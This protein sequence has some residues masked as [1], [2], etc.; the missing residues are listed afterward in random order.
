MTESKTEQ[1]NT[2]QMLEH[3][4]EPLRR[5]VDQVTDYAIFLLDPEGHIASWNAGAARIKGYTFEEIINQ[6]F[7]VFYRPEDR[8]RCA[9]ELEMAARDGRVED[10]GW[11]VRKDGTLFWADVVITCLRDSAGQIVGYGKVT[12]DLSERQRAEESLRQAEERFRLLV[13]SVKDYAIFMLDPGGHVTTWNAGAERIKGYRAGEI[14]GKHFSTFYPKED[15]AAGKCEMELEVAAREGRFEDE[16]WRLRKD[17]S[18]FWANVVIT[19]VHDASGALIGFAKVTRDLTERRAAEEERLRLGR[20]AQER[21]QALGELSEAL[22]FALS[23]DDVAR[24]VIQ[25]GIQLARGDTC[26]L[27]LLDEKTKTLELLAERGCNPEIVD[28]IRQIT[29]DAADPVYPVGTGERAEL[30]VETEAEYRALYPAF[31]ADQV[32][33]SG[34]QAFGCVPLVAEGKTIGMLGVGYREARDFSKDER[35]FVATVAQQ[36]AQA[37]ARAR[38]VEG[39]REAAALVDHLR[40]SLLTTL[41]SIGDALIATDSD[42]SISLMNDVAETLTG[43]SESDARGKS[44]PEV[45]HIINEHTRNIAENPVARVLATGGIVGLA[46]HTVLLA[47]DGREVPID[48]SGAPIRTRDGKIEGVVLVFRD[49]ST[50]KREEARRA[51]LADA[52]A[53]LGRSLDYEQTVAHVAQLCV[54][55]LADWCTVDLL[56][57]GERLPARLAV[58]HVDPGKIKLAQ[59]LAERYPPDPNHASAVMSVLQTGRSLLYP[60]IPDQLLVAGARDAEQLRIARELELRSAMIVPLIARG[61]VLGAMTFVYAES[62]RH[63]SADDLD[64][65]EQLA[66]RCAAAIDNARLFASE[67]RSRRAAEIANRAKDEFLAVVSHELRTPL[68]AIMGW[69]KLLV[70][71]QVD[72]ARQR[73]ALETVERNAVA[74]AQLVEDLLDMSRVVSGKL[75]LEVQQ[76]NLAQVTSAAIESVRPAAAARGVELTSSL[77]GTAGPVL[78]D[79]T[80]LQ[81]VIWNLLSNAVKFTSRDGGVRIVLRRVDFSVEISVADTGKGIAPSFLPHVFEA[82][83]QQDASSKRSLGGLGLGLAI[84]RQLVELHGGTIVAESDGEGCGAKFV[85][86]LPIA[87]VSSPRWALAGTESKRGSSERPEHLRGLRVLVIDDEMDT[88]N[89]VGAILEEC[90]CRVALAASVS[91]AMD[92][93]TEELPDLV[94]SDVGMPGEDGYDF[95][96]KLRALP[97]DRGGDLPAAA[98]TAYASAEDRGRLLNAGYSIHVAKPVDPAELLAVVGTLG[99]FAR[100]AD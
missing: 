88:R 38:R 74:M 33:G 3:A 36:C 28:R 78:G 63:Y 95:I 71:G 51:F 66:L 87:S 79:P 57:D 58:A 55:E 8:W 53:A 14:L 85:V 29:P 32:P 75:R 62:A 37:I 80:R 9:V 99:R 89:L 76:V 45:F 44:L 64:Y 98:L 30:W 52:T 21:V 72:Q 48:D 60:E 94:I 69:A 70:A 91:E 15:V 77:D 26:T 2:D 43:W 25:N 17:G 31:A 65:A 83:R 82:F 4:D 59:E 7:S 41:H 50:R 24:V 49:V 16:G 81:Q 46:N 23:I 22:T 12:R 1:P 47:R 86:T 73:N 90:G 20:L 40:A 11:R 92:A 93:L 61:K 13:E 34:V 67:Q 100:R 84:T 6:H 96:R 39:E 10:V 54:P 56:K 5:L 35:E 68:N 19:A 18:S 27:Y 97:R 42:G